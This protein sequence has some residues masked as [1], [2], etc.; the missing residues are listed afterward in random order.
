MRFPEN[1]LKQMDER[2]RRAGWPTVVGT[3]VVAA[4]VGFGLARGLSRIEPVPKPAAVPAVEPTALAP[5]EPAELKVPENYLAAAD[6]AVETV[7][8]GDVRSE[9]IAPATVVALPGGEAVVSSRVAGTVSRVDRR[10]GDPVKAGEVLALVDSLEAATLAA[11]RRVAQTRVDLARRTYERE[12]SLSEQG[13]TPRQDTEAAR[14]ALDVAQAE[15]ERTVAVARAAHLVDGRAVA[16]VSPIAGRITVQKALLGSHVGPD[17]ELFRVV[18]AGAVQVEAAVTAADVRRIDAGDEATIVPRAGAPIA[19]TVRSVTPTVSGDARSATVVLTPK[20]KAERL[21]VGEGVQARL[22]GRT[23]A[24]D[25]ITVPEDAV[26]NLAGR[27]AVFVRTQQGF[28]ARPVRVGARSNGVA[29][30][31]SGLQ[32]GER[33]ATRNAFL[34]KAETTKSGGNTE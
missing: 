33:V 14:A 13:V 23:G 9:L 31:V 2:G 22:H 19:A 16:L 25:G 5:A 1:E 30:V 10:L 21:V 6:I 12:R 11:E 32:P 29:Q 28:V 18:A 3:A 27:D 20:E 17:A 34:L 26:Q 15:V 4:A 7:G 8:R 24:A